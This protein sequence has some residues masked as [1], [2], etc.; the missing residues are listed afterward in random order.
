M[1]LHV[2]EREQRLPIPIGE[3]WAFFSDAAQPGADHPA[4]HGLRGHLPPSGAD[5]RGDDRHLPRPP[6]GGDPVTWVTEITHVDEPSGS[7]WTSSASGP[8]GSGTTSTTSARSTAG[9]RCADIIHY[10]LPRGAGPVRPLLV[11]PRLE[12]IFDHRRRVLAEMFGTLP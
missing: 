1:K 6:A 11:A 9:W 8:T 7:S 12:A 3:A 10:A 4:G 2:L 5:V